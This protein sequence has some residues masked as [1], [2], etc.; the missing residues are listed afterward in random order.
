MDPT[1]AITFDA[2]SSIRFTQGED[3]SIRLAF[4]NRLDGTPL[5]LTASS[6]GL[7]LSQA[8]GGNI[9]RTSAA[10]ML[11]ASMIATPATGLVLSDHGLVTGDPVTL[12]GASLPAPLVAA[13]PYKIIALDLN[14][15]GFADASGV[16]IV[17]TSAGVGSFTMSNATDVTLLNSTGGIALWTL[18]AAVSLAVAPGYAQAF[19]V[20]VTEASGKA[21]I[22]VL[23]GMLDVDAQPN[24]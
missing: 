11:N 4:I 16:P 17:L 2:G 5:D 9:K 19:Q 10:I 7:A 1:I 6:V 18:R 22:V 20:S 12:A 13:T 15:F 21:R 14:T 8:G 3:R 23:S 24:P